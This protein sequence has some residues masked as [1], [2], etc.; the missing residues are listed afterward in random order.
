MSPSPEIKLQNSSMR[1]SGMQRHPGS[2]HFIS[3]RGR[4][5]ALNV[6]KFC[7]DPRPPSR[8]CLLQREVF[9]HKARPEQ[10]VEKR[11]RTNFWQAEQTGRGR[12]NQETGLHSRMSL[13]YKWVN[14]GRE[15]RFASSRAK[16]SRRRKAISSCTPSPTRA[17]S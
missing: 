16:G 5:A 11:E 8:L 9:A 13:Y 15:A 3:S 17:P 7:R 6:G 2:L 1:V 10:G 4:H 14:G 12:E